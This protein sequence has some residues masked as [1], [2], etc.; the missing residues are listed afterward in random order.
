MPQGQFVTRRSDCETGLNYGKTVNGDKD[1]DQLFGDDQI[2]I[3]MEADTFLVLTKM[4]HF[5]SINRHKVLAGR[6]RGNG[7]AALKLQ[8]LSATMEMPPLFTPNGFKMHEV[9][10]PYIS[11]YQREPMDYR[12]IDLINI[13]WIPRIHSTITKYFKTPSSAGVEF[14]IEIDFQSNGFTS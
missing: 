5:I 4:D 10:I 3:V 14:I 6:Q 9:A 7:H 2:R 12:C 11:F 13:D 8:K 1:F